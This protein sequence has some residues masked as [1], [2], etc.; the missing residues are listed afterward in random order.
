MWSASLLFQYFPQSFSSFLSNRH[1]LTNWVNSSS[2][3]CDFD[4]VFGPW[5][6]GFFN[7]FVSHYKCF[8]AVKLFLM[9]RGLVCNMSRKNKKIKKFFFLFTE[10]Q[11]RGCIRSTLVSITR[12]CIRST[13]AFLNICALGV[14]QSI[15]ERSCIRSTQE[16]FKIK[17]LCVKKY[18]SVYLR[19]CVLVHEEV[20]I[21]KLFWY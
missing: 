13:L 21:G 1:F 15:F 6:I 18:T 12:N 8:V 5:G 17:A 7:F 10:K 2:S 19:G 3:A 9:G 16:N 4:R 11:K 14:H 20:L